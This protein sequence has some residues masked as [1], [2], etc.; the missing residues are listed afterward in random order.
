MTTLVF[1]LFLNKKGQIKI[2][3]CWGFALKWKLINRLFQLKNY[4]A[5]TWRAPH[6]LYLLPNCTTKLIAVRKLLISFKIF[7]RQIG[8]H[9]FF[10]SLKI[11]SMHQKHYTSCFVH[12]NF[13]KGTKSAI[14]RW[15]CIHLQ[16]KCKTYVYRNRS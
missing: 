1:K 9:H 10:N 5:A 15:S 7:L 6:S 11:Q 12:V 14:A 4:F 16:S 2:C 3:S 13:E 8:Q